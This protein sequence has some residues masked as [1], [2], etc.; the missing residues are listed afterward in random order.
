MGQAFSVVAAVAQP[1]TLA[2]SQTSLVAAAAP[3]AALS[4]ADVIWVMKL[5]FLV[6][7]TVVPCVTY[8]VSL[9]RSTA[10]HSSNSG[11]PMANSS[12]ATE[13]PGNEGGGI[14]AGMGDIEQL[15]PE[16]IVINIPL[17]GTSSTN[18]GSTNSTVLT[19]SIDFTAANDQM[20]SFAL[21]V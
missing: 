15:P 21:S 4:I 16:G 6:A 13:S 8:G 7:I 14:S 11:N 17:L 2:G 10:S 19:G 18:E 5:L 3:S 9:W 1:P 12:A 20:A